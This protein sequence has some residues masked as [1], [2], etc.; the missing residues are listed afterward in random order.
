V[1]TA[2]VGIMLPRDLPAHQIVPFVQKAEN[3]GFDE[4]W[5]VED[6]FFRG[7]FAQAA[8]ALASTTR[9]TVGIGILP[10]PVRN[11]V[12]TA[13]EAN[14]LAEIYPGRLLL[15]IGHGMPVWM[16]Q[17]GD[18]PASILTLLDEQLAALRT[19][20]AGDRLEVDGRYVRIDGAQLETP[21]TTAPPV[22]AGVRG[23]KSLALAGR[24]ADGT[25][26]A[27]PVTPE[28]LAA[29]LEHIAAAGPHQ[30]VAYNVATVDDDESVARERAR[31]ALE[32]IGEPDWAP[33]IAPLPFAAEFA[34]LRARSATRAE[35]IAALPD[36]WID[37]L[38]LVG[39]PDRVRARIAELHASGATSVVFIPAGP[40]P[41]AGL[42]SL[43]RAL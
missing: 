19:L 6:C 23:P 38:A 21:A 33:H 7:G 8:V 20:L 15:G 10:A 34:E 16:R 28:Y 2:T 11:A 24:S 30:L 36:A 42:D 25:I 35:F 13:L 43:A 26:L 40:D 39:T 27:E 5:V 4:V 29:A 17:V 3:L 31:P 41:L 37:E 32:W 1:T 9:I 18:K 14:T 12:F 22:L